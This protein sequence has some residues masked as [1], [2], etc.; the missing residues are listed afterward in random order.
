M[1]AWFIKNSSKN[2]FG[3]KTVQS[4]K[5][6]VFPLI[7]CVMLSYTKSI[8]DVVLW[9]IHCI[10]TQYFVM[11]NLENNDFMFF[12]VRDLTEKTFILVVPRM[13]GKIRATLC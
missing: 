8:T 2:I 6:F 11:S 9:T 10:V 13:P 5:R 4:E 7:I 12:R 3:M 1:L